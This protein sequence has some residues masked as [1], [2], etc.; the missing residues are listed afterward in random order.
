M[1]VRVG[2]M[3][4]FRNGWHGWMGKGVTSLGLSCAQ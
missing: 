1:V 3:G 2:A 4:L